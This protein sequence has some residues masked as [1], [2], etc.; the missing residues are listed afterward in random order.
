MSSF[1]VVLNEDRYYLGD[2]RF[3]VA[4]DSATRKL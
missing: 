1:D 3:Y 4:S 2:M